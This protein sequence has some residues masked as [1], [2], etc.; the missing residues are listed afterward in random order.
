[1]RRIALLAMIIVILSMTVS[2]CLFGTSTNE[3]C[4]EEVRKHC[5]G[6][7]PGQ[8]RFNIVANKL[9]KPMYAE[10]KKCVDATINASVKDIK[11]ADAAL[12]GCISS[13]T[14]LD[15]KTRDTLLK[16]IER[17]PI[18]EDQRKIWLKCYEALMIK[19]GNAITAKPIVV[20]MDSHLKDVVYCKHTQDVGGSNSDDIINLIKDLPL[21]VATVSTNLEWQDDQRVIN[22]NP[23]LIVL[24]ASA[25]YKETKEIDGNNRLFAFANNLGNRNI[26]ILV[27]SRGLTKES[28]KELRN[29]WDKI[30]KLEN[31]KN[32][33]L[34]TMPKGHESCFTDP[35]IGRP[36]KR[37]IMDML[38]MQ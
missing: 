37:K 18:P 12:K 33:Q 6:C 17:L 36:F 22:L 27:Y 2:G 1:M 14:K 35:D 3:L 32:I 28:S 5:A 26:K 19:K 8:E 20:L 13:N 23:A 10:L 25:F 21:N 30:K 15:E 11:Y 24:H 31:N 16:E 9:D 7:D 29:R 38:G 4:D 34:F